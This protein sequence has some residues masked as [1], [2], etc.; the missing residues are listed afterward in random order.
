MEESNSLD[1]TTLFREREE[2]AILENCR[3]FKAMSNVPVSNKHQHDELRSSRAKCYGDVL[4]LQQNVINREKSLAEEK[5]KLAYVESEISESE[6]QTDDANLNFHR[7]VV[8]EFSS[9]RQRKNPSKSQRKSAEKLVKLTGS[10]KTRAWLKEE[11]EREKK[12]GKKGGRTR[13][14]KK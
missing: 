11:E 7:S 9:G 12:K 4:T 3:R 10:F 2:R 1:P 14:I 5:A 8:S 6:K 13:R